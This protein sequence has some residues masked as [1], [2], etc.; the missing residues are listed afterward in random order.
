[1]RTGVYRLVSL[2]LSITFGLV[3]LLFLFV[4][5]GVVALFNALSPAFG[6]PAAPVDGAGFYRILA[7]AYMYLVALLAFM[8]FRHPENRSYPVLLVN[9]KAAS[10]LLS[11]AFFLVVHPYLAFISNG[12]VDGVLA[13][14]VALLNARRRRAAP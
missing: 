3:G 10:A 1:M 9:A 7:V 12:V 13:V 6:L 2:A 8:M 5:D 14:A 11:L 4:P